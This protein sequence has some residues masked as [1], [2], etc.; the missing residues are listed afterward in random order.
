LKVRETTTMKLRLAQAMAQAAIAQAQRSGIQICVAVCDENSRIF[1][2]LK[3]DDTDAMAGHEAMRR[4][5]TA[6]GAGA[7]SECAEDFHNASA[8][9]AMEG[10]GLSRQAGGLPLMAAG[11]CLGAI[12]VCG[13]SHGQDV[14]CAVAGLAAG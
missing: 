5:M 14:A 11:R 4:A 8:S 1:A 2:F 3:M 6:A 7:P 12:G 13:G 9:A 10:I